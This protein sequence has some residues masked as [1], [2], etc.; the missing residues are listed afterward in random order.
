MRDN[1]LLMKRMV[2]IYLFLAITMLS[3]A[4]ITNISISQ[5]LSMHAAVSDNFF[6]A[7]T[8]LSNQSAGLTIEG[9]NY[10]ILAEKKYLM[11]E[12]NQLILFATKSYGKNG[13]TVIQDYNGFS[14]SYSMQTSLGFAK[15]VSDNTSLGVRFNYF[16]RH[17]KGNPNTKSIGGEIS[18]KQKISN[19]LQSGLIII[20]PQRFFSKKNNNLPDN[21]SCFKWGLLY[22]V[23]KQFYLFIDVI[24]PEMERI[25]IVGGCAYNFNKRVDAMFSFS[26]QEMSNRFCI[27]FNLSKMKIKLMSSFHPQLGYSPSIML[28]SNLYSKINSKQ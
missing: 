17:L 6:D 24:K 28:L 2:N 22:D 13:V 5:K 14:E 12:L 26:V 25:G 3:K 1:I 18:I 8:I 16:L 27:G 15:Y 19:Y 9:L 21:E 20:N 11:N 7:A 4:Q 10:G 23:S